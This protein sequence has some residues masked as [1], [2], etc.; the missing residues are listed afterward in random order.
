[1]HQSLSVWSAALVNDQLVIGGIAIYFFNRYYMMRAV[2]P[3]VIH[4]G[5]SALYGDVKL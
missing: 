4:V 2:S 5:C 1:M 3:A